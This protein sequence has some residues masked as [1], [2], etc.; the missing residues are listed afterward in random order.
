[1][2]LDEMVEVLLEET[3]RT[4]KE[5]EIRRVV[6][7]AIVQVHSAGWFSRDKVED[8]IQLADPTLTK[9][10]IQHP[11][12]CRKL[13]IL[14]PL[15]AESKPITISTK[16]SNFEFVSSEG[17][18]NSHYETKRDFYYVAGSAIVICSSVGVP[19]LHIEW[20]EFP[21]V[22]DN[23][24]ETWLMKM[25]DNVFI[26]TAKSLFYAGIG[27]Q[28]TA[29]GLRTQLFGVDYPMLINTYSEGAM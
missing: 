11:E 14:K 20:Y 12:R 23:R 5:S 22:A 8:V 4:D 25:H 13:T 21:E 7:K 3:R 27:K 19:Q 1:M 9:F 24:L 10:K 29:N 28:D 17:I 26:D 15:S 6:R 16:D 2:T 18:M